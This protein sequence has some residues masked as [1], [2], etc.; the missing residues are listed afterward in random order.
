MSQTSLELMGEFQDPELSD[1]YG[2]LQDLEVAYRQAAE[3]LERLTRRR[4]RAGL[5]EEKKQA[6]NKVRQRKALI[7]AGG[8]ADVTPAMEGRRLAQWDRI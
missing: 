1:L 6:W 8:M 3:I 5:V 4:V 2:K 7:L